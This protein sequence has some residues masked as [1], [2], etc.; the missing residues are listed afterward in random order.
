MSIE[1]RLREQGGELIS[2]VVAQTGPGPLVLV[3]NV[4]W[5]AD[6]INPVSAPIPESERLPYYFVRLSKYV[7]D[8]TPAWWDIYAEAGGVIEDATGG[9]LDPIR[10]GSI[11]HPPQET[12]PRAFRALMDA[13][14]GGSPARMLRTIRW[15]TEDMETSGELQRFRT[16]AREWARTGGGFEFNHKH[17]NAIISYLGGV[18]VRS[19]IELVALEE[20]TGSSE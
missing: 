15:A 8:V 12:D 4:S 18:P 13:V 14:G 20:S 1:D 7:E 9:N 19:L 2:P 10:E 11:L 17:V 5:G 16:I 3:T 6:Y